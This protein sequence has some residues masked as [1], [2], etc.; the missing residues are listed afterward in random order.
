MSPY[1]I[2]FGK[3][4]HLPV[5]IEHR[6]FWA[7]KRCNLDLDQAGMER[8]LQLQELEEIRLEAYESSRLYKEKT[9]AFHDKMIMRKTFE[10]GQ[11]VP[12]YNSRLKLMP[13]KLRSRWEGPF[14]V[15]NVFPYGVVELQDV[16][17]KRS[18][19]ATGHRLKH[20]YDGFH[21]HSMEEVALLNATYQ[22]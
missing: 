6:A 13:G 4:C 15:T 21:E 18:F 20:F 9:K 1:R 10:A 12:L 16:T 22:T 2:I 8:K 19:K 3:A 14:M 5:E 7:V 11:K 17:T